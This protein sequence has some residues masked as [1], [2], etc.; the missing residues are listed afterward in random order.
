MIVYQTDSKRNK[1]LKYGSWEQSWRRLTIWFQ[2]LFY[3]SEL[4]LSYHLLALTSGANHWDESRNDVCWTAS[5]YFIE[6]WVFFNVFM[7]KIHNILKVVWDSLSSQSFYC[8]GD[9][10]TLAALIKEN[11]YLIWQLRVQSVNPLSSW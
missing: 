7:K 11:I 5:N 9:T 10:M 6:F 4:C 3:F 8:S 2:W 1:W